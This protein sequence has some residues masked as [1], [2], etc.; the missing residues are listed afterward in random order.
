M[1]HCS[2][3][4]FVS[5]CVP[6][7][8]LLRGTQSACGVHCGLIP[9][10]QPRYSP[11]LCEAIAARPTDPPRDTAALLELL[12]ELGVG[13]GF[14]LPAATRVVLESMDIGGKGKPLRT[15]VGALAA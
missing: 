8:P 12:L 4:T 1:L 6:N 15:K 2:P 14:K 7:M 10:S 11:I 5:A 9:A 3:P 13:H